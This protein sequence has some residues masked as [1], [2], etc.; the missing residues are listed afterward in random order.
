[1][2]NQK[3][4]NRIRENIVD[5]MNQMRI[6]GEFENQ[7]ENEMYFNSCSDYELIY[8]RDEYI[9]H[10]ME[11]SDKE[12]VN[13]LQDNLYDENVYSYWNIKK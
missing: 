3:L 8:Y 9:V 13:F 12:Y 5:I 10:V 4:S 7:P 1:M 6:N 2:K 11:F